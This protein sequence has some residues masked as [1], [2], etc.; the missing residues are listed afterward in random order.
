MR[1]DNLT[2]DEAQDMF[3]DFI[4]EIEDMT[5]LDEIEDALMSTFGLEPDY[6]DEVLE[7]L[8]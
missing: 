4:S 7:Y 8:S 6:I 1:R 5:S 3:D 2:H